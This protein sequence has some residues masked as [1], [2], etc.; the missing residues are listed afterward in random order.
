MIKYVGIGHKARQGKTLLAEAMVEASG[1]KIK[2]YALA[3]ELKQYCAAHHEELFKK[4]PEVPKLK[5]EDPIYGYVAMLQHYGTNVVRAENPNHWVEV[6]EQ[7]IEAEQ[8]EVALITDIRF[9][10][11]A[12]LVRNK[13][14]LLLRLRRMTGDTQYIDPTRSAQHPSEIGLDTFL[15]WDIL[16]DV[17]DGKMEELK[18]AGRLLTEIILNASETG[19]LRFMPGASLPDVNPDS[20]ATGFKD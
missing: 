19:V 7:K 1:G 12:A 13:E 5:K 16:L 3:E 14:G 20:D 6:L 17:Q 8:P 10:N 18:Q 11:E 2:T 4:Y 15:D 9:P